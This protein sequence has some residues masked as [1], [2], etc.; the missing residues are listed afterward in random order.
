MADF[1]KQC[2][3]EHFGEDFKELAGLS[4]EE[5]VKEGYY[6]VVM[7]EGCGPIQVDVEGRC[8]SSDCVLQHG[9]ASSDVA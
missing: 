7:C 9:K 2:S 4:T 8:I 3:E 5:R 6:A 1:C